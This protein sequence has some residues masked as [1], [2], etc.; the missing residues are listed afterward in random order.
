MNFR[1]D[2]D[3]GTFIPYVNDNRGEE[4][5]CYSF[6]S[7][8]T[9]VPMSKM[10]DDSLSIV[11]YIVDLGGKKVAVMEA[12]AEDYPG[13]FLKINTADRQSLTGEFAPYPL[14]YG[15]RGRYTVP[16]RSR[17][18]PS[19]STIASATEWGKPSPRRARPTGAS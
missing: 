12:G 3:Y 10:V 13:M 1:F 18:I 17:E 19:P 16:V 9:E 7:Y 4:R 15:R 6:E 8:Y 14:E 5:Y 2:K 11:P